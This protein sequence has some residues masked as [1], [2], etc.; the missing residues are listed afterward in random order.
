MNNVKLCDNH[1]YTCS[2]VSELQHYWEKSDTGNAGRL[3]KSTD[4]DGN[5]PLH[6]ACKHGFADVVKT[7]L[8][9]P[10]ADVG[11]K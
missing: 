7:L 5:T 1:M 4:E 11:A 9:M 10:G 3:V 8:K 6:L 2:I